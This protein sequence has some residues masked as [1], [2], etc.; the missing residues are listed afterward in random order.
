[1]V[2]QPHGTKR[3]NFIVLRQHYIRGTITKRATRVHH[4]PAD[5]YGS[6]IFT[7]A[8]RRVAFVRQFK[9]LNIGP[10]SKGARGV[11]SEP[12]CVGDLN[13]VKSYSVS[14]KPFQGLF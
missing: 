2:N 5:Q 14:L 8:F 13:P 10:P 9:H 11:N 3:R 4:F 12:G 6:N 1:M 7:K